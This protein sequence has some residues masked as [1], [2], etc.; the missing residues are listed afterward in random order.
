MIRYRNVRGGRRCDQN[1]PQVS[2]IVTIAGTSAGAEARRLRGRA[3][4]HRRQAD[5]AEQQAGRYEI[6]E[7]TEAETA[8][9][10]A[11]LAGIG[12]HLLAD[13][14][15]P[16]SKRAQVDI[17]VVGSAGVFIIDTKAWRE[18]SIHDDRIHRGQED[19]T[20]DI[21]RLADLVYGAEAGPLRDR[22]PA[23]RGPRGGR[24]RR[25]ATGMHAHVASVDVI[26]V[27][28]LVGHITKRNARL[29]AV[30]VDKVLAAVLA[31][32]P[33]IDGSQS[34][35]QQL[36]GPEPVLPRQD[37]PRPVAIH[38]AELAEQLLDG[39]LEAP[40]EEWMAFL[41]PSQAKLVRR[42]FNGPARIR[43]AAGIGKT[44]VGIHRAAYLARASTGRV[45]F[46]TY[47]GTLPRVLASL[48]E[49]H[50]PE[51]VDRMDFV[52]VHQFA[53]R[54][55]KQRGIRFRVDEREARLAFE[56][57]WNAVGGLQSAARSA[58]HTSLL[59]RRD[60]A[61][62]QGA[63]TDPLRA[64]TGLARSGRKH[65]LPVEVRQAVWDLHAAYDRG[66]RK[67]GLTDWEDVVL[68][69]RDALHERP[70]AD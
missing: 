60:Q 16:G 70:L 42:N 32:F 14:R 54:L 38:D 25:P 61:R 9:V 39:V 30:R 65:G 40:I 3:D 64:D 56:D 67:R 57:A 6:A 1:T 33:V 20:D 44:V 53:T 48:F 17:I 35:E 5:E 10:L 4:E 62:H 66:L 45:L 58:L 50:G 34:P 7:R 12:Y 47:I 24:T 52:G 31:H 55:L 69:T 22:P 18:V 13:R 59:G 26:G 23:G 46:A 41:D 51:L 28:D 68:L 37:L 36:T 49:S 19:V 63:G 15:W 8:R 27:H 29:S 11:P 2:I 21:A 43:G